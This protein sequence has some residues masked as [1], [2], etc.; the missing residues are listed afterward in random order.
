MAPR[1]IPRRVDAPQVRRAL[2]LGD[3]AGLVTSA[4]STAR[5]S[6]GLLRAP[7]PR[8]LLHRR[9]AAAAPK[10][11][12]PAD[13]GH[14]VAHPAE[15]D[16]T[17]IALVVLGES[18]ALGIGC[19]RPEEILA[20]QLAQQLADREHRPVAWRTV[21]A[22]GATVDYCTTHLLD[23]L[24]RTPA[25]VVAVVLGVNDLIRGARPAAFARDVEALVTRIANLAPGA[26][27]VLSGLPDPRWMP[28]L[29]RPLSSLLAV[30]ARAF[31]ERLAEA[32]HRHRLVHVPVRHVG[33]GPDDLA[34]DGSHPGPT[35]CRI[36]AAELLAGITPA[37]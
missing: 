30:R 15:G 19:T 3:M 24:A 9:I 8:E 34:S 22:D 4:A 29:P 20:A 17:E 5:A 7:G 13:G 25:D 26:Q 36:W 37:E 16:G 18:T 1:I 12:A 10:L 35:G 28:L 27:V 2:D 14:G 33:V 11:T 31:D 6:A 21:A 23:R 32:A